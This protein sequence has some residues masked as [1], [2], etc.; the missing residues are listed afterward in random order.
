M[1]IKNWVS[2]SWLKTIFAALGSLVAIT[3][4]SIAVMEYFE[5]TDG[6]FVAL[7]NNH[8]VA[9]PVTRNILI[10][11]DKDSVDMN[12]LW[13]L[14]KFS[15]PTKY[16]VEDMLITYQVASQNANIAYT[17][18][19]TMQRVANG[20]QAKNVDKTLYPRTEQPNA[21][22]QFI[23]RH[24][25]EANV[26]IRATYKG[27]D[28]PFEFE[29]RIL[30]KRLWNA[31]PT[32]RKQAV[33]ED[34][35]QYA[36]GNLVDSVDIY[37]LNGDEVQSY[38]GTSSRILQDFHE[39]LNAPAVAPPASNKNTASASETDAY[40][41]FTQ[42]AVE[43]QSRPVVKTVNQIADESKEASEEV[44]K[45]SK[46]WYEWVLI[47][48][49]W[50]VVGVGVLGMMIAHITYSDYDEH[51]KPIAIFVGCGVISS[52]A[53]FYAMEEIT[54]FFGFFICFWTIVLG[55]LLF[56]Y[57]DEKAKSAWKLDDDSILAGCIGFILFILVAIIC[58][59]I[60]FIS[61]SPSNP[62][63]FLSHI[64]CGGE[65]LAC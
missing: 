44:K 25:G 5:P 56:I 60:I 59:F 54:N 13:L 38:A 37:V 4:G 50:I 61:I 19:Y 32:A 21:F 3:S 53:I 14:P 51:W 2:K 8:E 62:L 55:I 7:V 48:L 11:M 65:F 18:D 1:G 20:E 52:L 12:K 26:K 47:V 17:A 27:V 23:M 40:K 15:N 43:K 24:G 64:G 46:K 42:E 9:P 22:M 29:S 35:Y 45:E 33:M 58:T 34:A 10:Y 28:I 57:L 49:C 36:F 39:L 16:A 6:K 63:W 41:S 30:A 31:D